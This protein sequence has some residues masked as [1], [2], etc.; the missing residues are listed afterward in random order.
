MRKKWSFGECLFQLRKVFLTSTVKKLD[1]GL[2][3]FCVFDYFNNLAFDDLVFD[4]F[5]SN[6]L[7]ILIVIEL[8]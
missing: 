6:L 7:L 8:D 2:T 4:N 1:F 3:D 5:S